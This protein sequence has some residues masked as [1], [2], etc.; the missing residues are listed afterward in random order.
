MKTLFFLLIFS[1]SLNAQYYPLVQEGSSWAYKITF[2]DGPNG[3]DYFFRIDIESDTIVNGIVYNKLLG[4]DSYTQYLAGLIREENKQ[5][6]FL[7]LESDFYHSSYSPCD[8][9]V[10]EFLLYDFNLQKGDTSLLCNEKFW[11]YED[12]IQEINGKQLPFQEL[13]YPGDDFNDD[14]GKAVEGIG[15]IE[16][17]FFSPSLGY[18]ENNN[19]FQCVSNGEI[20]YVA[21][22]QS[23][24]I[25]DNDCKRIVSTKDHIIDQIVISPNPVNSI[26]RFSSENDYSKYNI[27]S[28]SGKKVQSGML[29]DKSISVDRLNQGTYFLQLKKDG[30]YIILPFY[31]Q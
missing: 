22:N 14:F 19:C 30:K 3:Q 20:Q 2:Y 7:P 16:Q 26:L 5:V 27:F 1:A 6:H 12:G 28:P 18:F 21:P 17:G 13:K 25:I 10:G 29:L 15:G 9:F 8:T 23:S 31:K 24:Y 4:T 11:V